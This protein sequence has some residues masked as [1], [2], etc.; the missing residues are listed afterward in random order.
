MDGEELIHFY[1]L[2][3]VT[4]DMLYSI[5]VL[6]ENRIRSIRNVSSY[7]GGWEGDVDYTK[8]RLQINTKNG[9]VWS[10]WS[11]R[12]AHERLN[13]DWTQRGDIQFYHGI[14]DD[15]EFRVITSIITI[16]EDVANSGSGFSARDNVRN[17]GL[18]VRA[19][20]R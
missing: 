2:G 10:G 12:W 15:I 20:V 8:F 6:G 4:P 17:V 14:H 11:Q 3:P 16:K 9:G 18:T 19:L 13:S 7:P 1:T 5:S